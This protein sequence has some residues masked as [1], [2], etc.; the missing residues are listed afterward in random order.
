[1]KLLIVQIALLFYFLAAQAQVEVLTG[2]SH[3]GN[4]YDA[5]I[6]KADQSNL[7]KFDILENNQFIP[8]DRFTRGLGIDSLFILIN[9]FPFDSLCRPLGYFCRNNKVI[10]MV[11]TADGSSNFFLKPNGLFLITDQ[12]AVIC[13]SSDLDKYP[14]VRLGFQSGPMLVSNGM[15]HPKFNPGSANKNIRAGVGVFADSAQTRYI[16]LCTS[17]TVVTFHQFAEVFK[18]KF[19][20]NNALCLQSA[21]CML[22]YP[23]YP[24][25]KYI[26]NGLICSYI[27][28]GF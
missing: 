10:S 18:E 4:E 14:D 26:Y 24:S 8:N 21:G 19:N 6:L 11:N 3:D 20:C 2:F 23:L 27:Y 16:V 22:Y 15:I 12:D 28:Y 25:K 13:E 5:V 9:A 1:M 7:Q 17:N